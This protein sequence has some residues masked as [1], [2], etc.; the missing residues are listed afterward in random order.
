MNKLF[1]LKEWLTLKQAIGYISVVLDE[2]VTEADI[3][4]L[5][6]DDHLT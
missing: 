2:P 5:A 4:R 1:K 6:L 3:Y